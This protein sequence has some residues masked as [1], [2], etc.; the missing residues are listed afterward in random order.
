[1]TAQQTVPSTHETVVI[2]RIF[3]PCTGS[4][5]KENPYRSNLLLYPLAS[6][7]PSAAGWF[8]TKPGTCR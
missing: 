6:Q 4:R 3:R 8:A 2:N 5:S 7:M 1:V